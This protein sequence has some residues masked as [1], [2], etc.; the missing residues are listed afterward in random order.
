MWIAELAAGAGSKM[1]GPPGSSRRQNE[2]SYSRVRRARQRWRLAR[3]SAWPLLSDS[4]GRS[5][6]SGTMPAGGGPLSSASG[7]PSGAP[8]AWPM[9]V[10][11]AATRMWRQK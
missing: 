4:T 10:S 2:T 8:A 11:A 5:S 7:T 9:S 3:G 6:S 1:C